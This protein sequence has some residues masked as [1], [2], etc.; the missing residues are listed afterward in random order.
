MFCY[1]KIS[2]HKTF[3]SNYR[4]HSSTHKTGNV[5]IN[6]KSKRVR[7]TIVVVENQYL[8]HI[9]SVRLQP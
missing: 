8:L 7:V 3:I 9:L 1:L 2:D 6:L 4:L 5:R